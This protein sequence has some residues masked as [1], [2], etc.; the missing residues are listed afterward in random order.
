MIPIQIES[1]WQGTADCSKCGI[2]DM[3]LFADLNHQ[4]FE[5]IHTPIDDLIYSPNSVLHHEAQSAHHVMTLRRGLVKLA[6][7]TADGRQRIVRVLRPG[8]VVG[9]EALATSRYASEAV[10]L[11]Q[12]TLC[13]IPIQVIQQLS[14]NSSRLHARLMEKWQQALQSADD[15]LTDLNFGSAQ[16]RVSQ[17]LLKM[18]D[19]EQPGMVT[20]FGR[21]DMGAMLDLKLETVSR[22]ISKLIKAQ[23]IRPLDPSGRHF[24]I[25]RPDVLEDAE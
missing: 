8:D 9:I 5:Q 13:R 20:I 18:R 17:L 1:A 25:L 16:R 21:D 24:E 15:W 11:T 7:Y 3:A 23:A 12:V 2:R 6:R 4:D 10:A 14:V 19:V 22:E